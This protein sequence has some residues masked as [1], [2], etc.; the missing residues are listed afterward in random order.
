MSDNSA[1]FAQCFPFP[2]LVLTSKPSS[3]S[4]S[5]GASERASSLQSQGGK[6]RRCIVIRGSWG[7]REGGEGWGLVFIRT[8]TTFSR[9]P[10]LCRRLA[11]AK[12]F[13]FFKKKSPISLAG[14]GPPSPRR[15][16]PLFAFIHGYACVFGNPVSSV[17]PSLSSADSAPP[18]IICLSVFRRRYPP[19]RNTRRI[20]Q[21]SEGDDSIGGKSGDSLWRHSSGGTA[22]LLCVCPPPP[23][24]AA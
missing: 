15:Y 2:N 10:A 12:N 23:P 3:L 24:R 18:L 6:V 14:S 9:P 8:Q 11:A 20:F 17:V 13:F 16:N 1:A 7:G 22:L 21:F 19:E 5:S 4:S